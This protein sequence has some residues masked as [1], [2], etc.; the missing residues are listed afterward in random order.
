MIDREKNA[1]LVKDLM[2][3]AK[4]IVV[5][6]R[7]NALR[8]ELRRHLAPD[9]LISHPNE[10][11]YV[12]RKDG[13][14]HL[15]FLSNV[16]DLDINARL[17]FKDRNEAARAWSINSAC[18]TPL[19]D[20]NGEKHLHLHP[21][22]SVAV[23][24]STDLS[25]AP[26]CA[27]PPVKQHKRALEGWSLS[28]EGNTIELPALVTWENIK[29]FE[30]Y[31]GEGVYECNFTDSD[32]KMKDATLCFEELFCAARVFLNGELIGDVWT[33]PTEIHLKGLVKRGVNVLR[34]SV[35][36]TLINEMLKQDTYETY[37]DVLPEW[38]Y[39]GTVINRQRA[40]RLNC[41]LERREQLTPLPSGIRG[42]VS[43]RW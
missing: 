3:K 24:F 36:S 10:I 1:A 40:A 37:P 21:Y 30:S 13:D 5:S 15:Y 34:I 6:N 2:A 29:G 35:Y 7:F 31:S 16:S 39:Y 38:P 23:V 42:E 33:N 25:D 26:I 8:E 4:P 17:F 41:A 14:T 18:P 32:G 19:H 11:G 22:E 20:I 43:L 28:I 9:V 12:H 27:V